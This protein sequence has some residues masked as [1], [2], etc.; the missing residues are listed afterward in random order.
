M[1]VEMPGRAT[2]D[3]LL[4]TKFSAPRGPKAMVVRCRLL[5]TLDAGVHGP[6]T[7][8]A[9]PAG[10]GKT[11]LVSAWIADSRPPGPVG[12]LSLD[13][14][15]A[16]RRRFWRAVLEALTRA[17]GDELVAG[18]AV[19]PREPLRKDVVLSALVDALDGRDEPVVLVLEDFHEVSDVVSDDV[20]RLVRF[21][22]AA[23]RLV[24][25][26]RADPAIG[27]GRLRLDGRLTEIRAADLAFTLPEAHAMF[28]ALGID[29]A[30]ADLERLW[31]RTEGWAAALRLAAASL[32]DHHDPAAFVDRFAGTEAT[33]S[34]YLLSEV[35]ARQP[36]DL[37]E[38]LLRTSVVETLNAE[39][40]DAL[41]GRADGHSMIARLEHGSVLT[42]PLD[43]HGLWHRY[44]PLFAELLRAELHAQLPGE[45]EALHRRAAAWLAD[46]ERDR[47]ALRH[48]AAGGAWDLAAD[49]VAA[50]GMQFLIDGEIA[51][52]APIVDAMP[53]EHVEASPELALAFAA[54]LL[55]GG[56]HRG[57]APYLRLAS[58]HGARVPA[59][60]LAQFT[61]SIAALGLYEGRLRGEPIR[62]L[63]EART[64][65]QGDVVLD[66]DGVSRGVRAFVLGQLGVV[67]LWT[68][69]LAA[70]VQHLEHAMSAAAAAEND[71]TVLAA[72]AYLAVAYAIRGEVPR[73]VRAAES[74]L[75]LAH[76]RGWSRTE[77]T[78]AALCI[79]AA[80][81]IE[82]G[83][84]DDGAALLDRASDAL[85]GARDR[86]LRAVLALLRAMLLGDTGRP[87]TAL[88]VLQ[89]GRDELGDWPLLP[90]L[91]TQLT[92]HEALLRSALGE[93]D[94]GQQLLERAETE[95]RTSVPVANA[96]AKLRLLDGDAIAARD[97]LAP[98]L[99][100]DGGAFLEEM[101]LSI[102]AEA[103]LLDAMALDALAAHEA[104]AR[105]LERALDLAE[106]AGLS[107]LI[108]AQGAA[109]G[110]L[111]RRHT[112]HGTSHPAIVGA[113]LEALEQRGQRAG[114]AHAL[115]AEPLSEREQVIL[116]YLPTMMSNQE[117]A[118]EL[119]VS[120]NT[121]KTHLKA[122]YRKLDARG[123]REAVQR[124]RELGLMP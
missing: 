58:D 70:A 30:Q 15:D 86:P 21:Q 81:A 84:R 45:V 17:T 76:R 60:R 72:G 41:T 82:Q 52:L 36:A 14:D 38:F 56:D 11:A 61:A 90:Q 67:E 124:G 64:V 119:Y 120:I 91:E 16:D 122:I 10:A 65:L 75:D 89:A 9:A 99:E 28:Q 104:A 63:E 93:R 44:H 7:L 98:H 50:R 108:L 101:P 31:Q 123:R 51:A 59:Q 20:E 71:W 96:L 34:D 2:S 105:S 48:A 32:R 94:A 88:S 80:L 95:A 77:P 37:R 118:G 29:L 69:D 103:W 49:L 74:A 87:D 100:P 18:L 12:W 115:L 55:G 3:A 79:L 35:L 113:T 111:L 6:V 121:V 42:T 92:A 107:R 13:A 116:R 19:S 78:G 110:P 46:H 5:E 26:T 73:A 47:A 85:R 109:V 114:R 102:R 62:A 117:I 54:A 66:D 68:G 97:I 24:I 43:D 83:R 33:I 22:P 57:A 23:L 40:A 8:L 4:A 112:R 53:R 106:P 25:I 27:L 39:L 1:L